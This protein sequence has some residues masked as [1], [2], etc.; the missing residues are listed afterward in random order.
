MTY[1]KKNKL[2]ILS[3]SQGLS[4]DTTNITITG[5][6]DDD[7][8]E[9]IIKDNISSS[10]PYVSGI[11]SNFIKLSFMNYTQ[12]QLDNYGITAPAV[13]LT[14]STGV[15]TILYVITSNETFHYLDPGTYN[16]TVPQG[17]SILPGGSVNITKD[18]EFTISVAPISS[19]SS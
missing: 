11:P 13:T 12:N 7:N 3:V 14:S 1:F 4:L 6:N 16:V 9:I 19:S 2:N 17:F 18:T 10:K 15:Q 5:V 8:K